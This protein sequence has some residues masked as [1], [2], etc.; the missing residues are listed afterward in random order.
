MT[1]FLFFLLLVFSFQAVSAQTFN[2]TYV[3]ANPASASVYDYNHMLLTA[4]ADDGLIKVDFLSE[5]LPTPIDPAYFEVYIAVTKVDFVGNIMWSRKIGKANF[6]VWPAAIVSGHGN[7]ESI[8]VGN[9]DPK[10]G[11]L[12]TRGNAIAFKI[13]NTS[14]TIIWETEFNTGEFNTAAVLQAVPGTSDYILAGNWQHNN[15]ATLMQ[16]ISFDDSGNMNWAQ[17]Y[18]TPDPGEGTPTS[19]CYRPAQNVVKVMGLVANHMQTFTIGLDPGTGSVAESYRIFFYGGH[20]LE[21]AGFIQ[22]TSDDGYI[23]V[24]NTAPPVGAGSWGMPNAVVVKVDNTLVENITW[25]YRYPDTYWGLAIYEDA[26]ISGQYDVAVEVANGNVLPVPALLTLDNLGNA[27]GLM[28]YDHPKGTRTH[29][30]IPNSQGGYLINAEYYDLKVT[31]TTSGFHL[32]QTDMTDA[33]PCHDPIPFSTASTPCSNDP[34]LT[35]DTQGGTDFDPNL[36]N[37]PMAFDQFDCHAAFKKGVSVDEI[38]SGVGLA[39]FPNPATDQLQISGLE[40]S[41]APFHIYNNL[42]QE[43]MTGKVKDGTVD[44]AALPEGAY[45]LR[46]D[47]QEQMLPFT[48]F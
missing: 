38:E 4:E 9:K 41:E 31:P 20:V 12:T 21:T 36:S 10:G 28:L 18:D 23:M 14:G 32:V 25:K 44:V 3:L 22:P 29:C 16:A 26:N 42:G 8:I 15:S 48:K 33:A 34:K 2:N 17:Q 19:I 13:D 47:S 27:V 1:K 39:V 35:Y 24:V 43:I 6:D 45:Y 30:M 5:S 46:F 11:S 7:N 37:V 40:D